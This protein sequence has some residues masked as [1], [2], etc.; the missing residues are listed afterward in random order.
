MENDLP[1]LKGGERKKHAK[2]AEQIKNVIMI[3]FMGF[4]FMYN[5]LG[6]VNRMMFCLVSSQGLVF[7]TKCNFYRQCV[8]EL[9]YEMTLTG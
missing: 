1:I 9:N 8:E 7:L 4:F 5:R 6:L 3:S 2:R